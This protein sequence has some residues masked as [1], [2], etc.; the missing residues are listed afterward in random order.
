MSRLIARFQADQARLLG[1]GY[2]ESEA[3]AEFIDPLLALLGWDMVNAAGQ[4]NSLK[5]VVREQSHEAKG[6]KASRRPDYTFRVAGARKFFVEAKKP[7]VNIVNHAPSALQVRRYG[8]TAGLPVSIL[9]NFRTL[10]IYDTRLEP[11]ESD[12]A[13]VGLINS[14]ELDQLDAAFADLFARFGRDNVVAGALEQYFGGVTPGSMDVG[15]KFLQRINSWRVRLANDLLSRDAT[16]TANDLSDLTQ[17]LINRIIFIRMCEDRE[18]EPDETLRSAALTCDFGAVRTLFKQLDAR[19]GGGLFTVGTDPFQRAHAIDGQL[20]HQIVEE[21]YAPFSPYS[22]AVL[23]AE[24][25]G[26]VYELFLAQKLEIRAGVVELIES[27][28]AEVVTTPQL[29]VE[30]AVQR[31]I[32]ARCASQPVATLGEV[33]ALRLLDIAVGSGRFLVHALDQLVDRAIAALAGNQHDPRLYPLE[34]GQ[35]RLHFTV[36]KA[37]L[38]DCLFGIDI[39]YNAV[40]VARFNLILKLLED[41]SA[42]TL[43]DGGNLLPDLTGNLCWGNSVVGDVLWTADEREQLLAVNWDALNLPAAFDVIVGNPPYLKAEE[44]RK[45][46]RLEYTYYKNHYRTAERQFDKYF[47][48]IERAL[49]AV[50]TVGAIGM[51]VPN[52][53]MTIEAG[54]NLRSLLSARSVVADIVDFGSESMFAGKSIYICLLVLKAA[55]TP[56]FSYRHVHDRREFERTPAALGLIQTSSILGAQA[57][58]VPADVNEDRVLSMLNQNSCPLGRVVDVKNGIQTSKNE[59]FVISDYQ[60]NGSTLSFTKDGKAWEIEKD[61][62]R[63][64]LDDSRL[65]VMSYLP[66]KADAVVIFPYRTVAGGLPEVIPPALLQKHF[67]LAWNYLSHHQAKLTD[68]NVLPTPPAD[69]FY[70]FG[71]RQALETVFLSPKIICTVNQLGDKYAWDSQDGVA[72]ASG[73]TAGEIMLLN[74]H[75]GYAL[76]FVLGLLH[77]RAIEFYVRKRGSPFDN[78]YYSRGTAVMSDIPVPVLNTAPRAAAHDAIVANVQNIMRI[79]ADMVSAVGRQRVLLERALAAQ[80]DAMRVEFD[81]LWGFSGEPEKLIM[82]GRDPAA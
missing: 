13:D 5:D 58:M 15:K 25:L 2:T 27:A 20:F 32:A 30:Q 1:N 51:V 62:T 72:V 6:G 43:P 39:D 46:T 67:P 35:Y 80:K 8:Y 55:G 9:T 7:A 54:V 56:H 78:G 77:Q 19:Y 11:Q 70:A 44:I 57:W 64:Y 21:V 10:R 33:Q 75:G 17:T 68:R 65:G 48:F 28:A 66:V 22:F 81:A 82:P 79:S 41:E 63:P 47:V 76:E 73:G 45:R 61:I 24:F 52:K 50:N 18:I 42:Q 16:L 69:V 53:W 3:R 49:S 71:R 29:L 26:Q 23:D 60:D 74:P 59:I 38:Q 40:E 4:P 34:H 14:I 31:A 37:L 12:D 36:K